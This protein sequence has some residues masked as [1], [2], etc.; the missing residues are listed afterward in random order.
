MGYSGLK[1]GLGALA[2]LAVSAFISVGSSH[3]TLVLEGSDATGPHGSDASGVIYTTQLFAFMAEGSPLPILVFGS[4]S[5][6]VSA[7]AGTVFTTDLTGLSTAD[8]SG[9][10]IQSPGGCC[11]QNLAGALPYA[12]EIAAF[13]AAG[14]SVA[15]MDYQ[16]G[17][18]SSMFP[19]LG[20]PPAGTV[21][22]YGTG[23][24]GPSCTDNEVFNAD[25]LA[26]G[27]T[28]PGALGCWEHQAYSNDYFVDTLGF[29]SLVDADPAYFGLNNDGSA[30]GS[31]FLALGGALGTGGCTNP[32]GCDTGKV[33]EPAP[34]T[35]LGLGLIALGVSRR[36]RSRLSS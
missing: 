26:K 16:G 36:R 28:Q 2:A 32:A 11:N 31:A 17:D 13:F 20:T 9:L 12:T 14:G 34:I 29:L 5:N 7:P 22:G 24:G 15:I 4:A 19:I 27:F 1:K 21:M 25:G 18:W 3:A 6:T 33:P 10:Y 23:G 35:F 8:Y 30:R